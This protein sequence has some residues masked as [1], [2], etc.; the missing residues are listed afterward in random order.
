MWAYWDMIVLP[1]S[2]PPQVGS[3]SAEQGIVGQDN[4][5]SMTITITTI[6]TTMK[7]FFRDEMNGLIDEMGKE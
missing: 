6:K 2:E 3:K 7:G 1:N 5:K 4:T